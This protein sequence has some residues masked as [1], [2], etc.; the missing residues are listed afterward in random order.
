MTSLPID[1]VP[2][3]Q[4][5]QVAVDRLHD[6][7][8]GPGRYARTAYRVRGRDGHDRDLSFVALL[9]GHVVGAVW[10]TRVVI[11]AAPAILLGPI[12]VRA[13]VAGRGIGVALMRAAIDAARAAG[14]PGIVL[15]GDAPYYTRV[16]FTPVRHGRIG[17]PGPVDPTRVLALG[18]APAVVEAWSGPI[19]RARWGA[20]VEASPAFAVPSEADAAE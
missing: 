14:A 2:E 7:V 20:E 10:Q 15:V 17:W 8:F 16:G 1:I 5:H 3:R 12:A 9:D 11:G 18:L 13:E 4:G 6:Q 19:R